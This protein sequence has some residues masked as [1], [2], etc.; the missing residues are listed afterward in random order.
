M[1]HVTLPQTGVYDAWRDAARAHLTARTPPEAILWSRGTEAR[2]LFAAD[3]PPPAKAAQIT[4]PKSFVASTPRS[5]RCK[6]TAVS[7]PTGATRVRRN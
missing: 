2:D 6:L 3:T 7:L 4:V 5:G 1:H